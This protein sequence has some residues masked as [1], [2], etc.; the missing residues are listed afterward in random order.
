MTFRPRPQAVAKGAA[1]VALL[2]AV[3]LSPNPA[4]ADALP[5]IG[6]ALSQTSVSGLSSGAFMA[7]QLEIAHSDRHR[8]RGH[9]RRRP[10]R[11]CRDVGGTLVPL[12]ADGRGPERREGS[13][14]VHED[15]PR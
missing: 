9:C 13:P 3:L 8:G 7:G 1:L 6:A 2:G 11:L 4:A 12:L 10:I 14:G 15:N 5:K